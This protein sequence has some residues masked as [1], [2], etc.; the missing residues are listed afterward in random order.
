MGT[1]T[2]HSQARSS[3]APWWAVV[4]PAGTTQTRPPRCRAD[5]RRRCGGAALGGKGQITVDGRAGETHP[6]AWDDG[7]R[8]YH[9]LVKWIEVLYAGAVQPDAGRAGCGCGSGEE[10][11]G[12]PR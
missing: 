2:H 6:W 11:A 5:P 3:S 1:R 8:R 4:A 10:Q 7:A 12:V 9:S